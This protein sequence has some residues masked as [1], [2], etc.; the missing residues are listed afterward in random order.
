MSYDR[1]TCSAII[2]RLEEKDGGKRVGGREVRC[3]L[4]ERPQAAPM[5]APT[6]DVRKMNGN[7]SNKIHNVTCPVILAQVP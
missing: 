5:D 7:Q 6:V 4:G 1:M 3:T 2:R